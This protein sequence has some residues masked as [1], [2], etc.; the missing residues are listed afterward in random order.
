VFFSV[1]Y[2]IT[3]RLRME[4]LFS[5]KTSMMIRISFL[6]LLLSFSSFGQKQVPFTGKLT[7]KVEFADTNFRELI[8]PSTMVVY[9]NDTLIRIENETDQLGK[10]VLIKHLH[11]NKSYLLLDT[12]LGKFAIQTDYAGD[13]LP[14]KYTFEKKRGKKKIA[15]IKARKLLVSHPDMKTKREFLY[16]RKYSSVYLNNFKD[17]PGLPLHY[18]IINV[19]GVYEYTLQSMEIMLP[20]KDLFGIPSDYRRISYSDF[21]DLMTGITNEIQIE[22]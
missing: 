16:T 20:E 12:P 22:E 1:T 19:D 18:Y 6:F 11:L 13:T 15:G 14:S 10:Q 7:Y 3:S 8:P 21:V 5:H 2:E 17:F 9:S 4:T